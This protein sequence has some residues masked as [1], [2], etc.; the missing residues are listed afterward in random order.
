M[1]KLALE[2]FLVFIQAM[3]SHPSVS[4]TVGIAS[5]HSTKYNSSLGA[6]RITLS[7]L[8]MLNAEEILLIAV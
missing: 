6:S 5:I 3:E 8:D 4:S 1:L 7:E 2:I